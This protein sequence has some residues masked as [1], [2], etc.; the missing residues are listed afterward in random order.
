MEA[1]HRRDLSAAARSGMTNVRRRHGFAL[2]VAPALF[3]VLV[4]GAAWVLAALSDLQNPIGKAFYALP[5]GV[6]GGVLAPIFILM[7]RQKDATTWSIISVCVTCLGLFV[8]VLLWFG[9]V[10]TACGGPDGCFS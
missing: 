3:V 8:A 4:E 9:A 10:G 5:L 2:A 6:V 1:D 7:T